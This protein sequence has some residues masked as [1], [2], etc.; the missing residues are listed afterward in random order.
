M[1]R[2]VVHY[3]VISLLVLFG[4]PPSTMNDVS[5]TICVVGEQFVENTILVQLI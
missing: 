4:R 3:Y 1:I 2:N 5:A